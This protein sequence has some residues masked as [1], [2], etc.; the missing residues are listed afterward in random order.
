MSVSSN[1]A[2][3]PPT[4]KLDI[5]FVYVISAR[6]DAEALV[7]RIL[8]QHEYVAL[9]IEGVNLGDGPITLVQIAVMPYS[10]KGEERRRTAKYKSEDNPFESLFAAGSSLASSPWT[11]MRVETPQSPSQ[12]NGLLA[13]LAN[14]MA[15]A[16][17]SDA[18]SK[19]VEN[20][21]ETNGEVNST[22]T[23]KFSGSQS[24]PRPRTN[25]EASRKTRPSNWVKSSDHDNE[26]IH[27]EIY[28]FDIQTN[29]SLIWA[30]EPLF[31]S[32]DVVKVVHDA[33]GDVRALDNYYGIRL[34]RIFDTQVA[35]LL[36]QEFQE[37]NGVPRRSSLNSI[38]RMYGGAVN[39]Y[40]GT[41]LW[42]LNIV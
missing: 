20:L 2:A 16:K 14:L 7:E 36:I 19:S 30:L 29:N 38:A 1:L 13:G 22:K 5:D 10:T 11:A 12:D 35:D 4:V 33:R 34:R 15:D 31:T 28:L 23:V 21:A 3:M 42:I 27:P 37:G 24:A 8:T 41:L 17:K 40:K 6:Y 9:D 18:L 26:N 25:S 39:P 32:V